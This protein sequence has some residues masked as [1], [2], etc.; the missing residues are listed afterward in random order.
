MTGDLSH[1]DVI[2]HVIVGRKQMKTLKKLLDLEFL[3]HKEHKI[4]K[5]V[6]QWC[7]NEITV[8]QKTSSKL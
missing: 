5:A 6:T 7:A 8:L 1:Y 2:T 4:K 3:T